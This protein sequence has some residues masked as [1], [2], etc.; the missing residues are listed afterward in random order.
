VLCEDSREACVGLEPAV[1]ICVCVWEFTVGTRRALHC[2]LP[3]HTHSCLQDVSPLHLV[4]QT[5]QVVIAHQHTVFTVVNLIIY[6][7]I[8]DHLYGLT[9]N[10]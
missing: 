9:T 7:V 8:Y 6:K 3:T 4:L 5:A 10:K 1:Y 2:P